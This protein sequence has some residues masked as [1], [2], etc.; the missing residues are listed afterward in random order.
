MKLT[1]IVIMKIDANDTIFNYYNFVSN[2]E[3]FTKLCSIMLCIVAYTIFWFQ[4]EVKEGFH[5]IP[6]KNI[7]VFYY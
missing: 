1:K 6:P 7:E 5:W 3:L 2:G 4:G